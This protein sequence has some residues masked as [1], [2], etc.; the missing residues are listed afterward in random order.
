MFC[1]GN[2]HFWVGIFY[3]KKWCSF[4]FHCFW[5]GNVIAYLNID[6][7]VPL[8]GHK[9][10]FFFVKNTCVNFIASAQKFYTNYILVNASIIIFLSSMLSVFKRMVCKV[11]FVLTCKIFFSFYIIA[12]DFVKCKRSTKIFYVR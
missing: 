8:Y 5:A 7:F 9:I 3:A 4:S 11:I 1:S 6:F 2:Y 12:A 10:N